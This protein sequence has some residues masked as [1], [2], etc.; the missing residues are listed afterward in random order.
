MKY[1][2]VDLDGCI[3]DDLWRRKFIRPLAEGAPPNA[4]RFEHYHRPSALDAYANLDQLHPEA[5][6]IVLTARPTIYRSQTL[7]WL[8][9]CRRVDL[10]SVILIMRNID[11]HRTSLLLKTEMVNWLPI[12]YGIPLTSIVQAIDD[13]D[14][15]VE[16][17]R[18]EYQLNARV[19]RIGEEA[20]S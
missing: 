9:G 1:Q 2:I 20:S 14:D 11:D 13:R 16:M 15:I 5:Q 12:H 17:Y 19:V 7:E 8:A 3:S 10:H 6:P 18:S 4:E